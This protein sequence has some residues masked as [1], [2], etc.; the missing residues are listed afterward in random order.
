VSSALKK[1]ATAN[2]IQLPM[3]QKSPE[4][5]V[6]QIRTASIEQ[7]TELF[8][9]KVVVDACM[10]DAALGRLHQ[11]NISDPAVLK[12]VVV[13]INVLLTSRAVLA[14]ERLPVIQQHLQRVIEALVEIPDDEIAADIAHRV[15]G[16]GVALF[17]HKKDVARVAPY[18]AADVLTTFEKKT[19]RPPVK[20]CINC[21]FNFQLAS[22]EISELCF[23][24]I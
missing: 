9:S 6:S 7:L 10:A 12:S 24:F 15:E 14:I 5:A 22:I 17:K 1:L 23:R 2:N 18:F 21:I 19:L 16:I 11:F 13:C 3:G 20:V 4:G 8:K